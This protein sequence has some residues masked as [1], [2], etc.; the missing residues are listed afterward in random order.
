MP[1]L[2]LWIIASVFWA[3]IIAN[4][5]GD[6][7]SLLI[8][9]HE[10]AGLQCGSCHHESPPS[11]A[12]PNSACLSCHGDQAR[13]AGL[14]SNAV[15]NPHAPPHLES[16]EAQTCSDCHHIHKPSEVS[17]SDCHHSFQFNVK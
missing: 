10:A 7:R 8:D 13:L 11:A 15:P 12:A 9:R 14:T 2:L 6:D 16:G 3:T 4:C 1:R 5:W 17:C